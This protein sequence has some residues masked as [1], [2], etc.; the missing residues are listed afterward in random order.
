VRSA[1]KKNNPKDE[2]SHSQLK[3]HTPIFPHTP[4]KVYENAKESK[5]DITRDFKNK[6]LIYSTPWRDLIK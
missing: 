2:S 3:K 4:V 1:T 6:T 5:L